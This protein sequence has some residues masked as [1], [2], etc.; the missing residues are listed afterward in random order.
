M[1]YLIRHGQTDW[2][3]A[4]KLQGTT[5]IP[6][7]DTGR[8][9]AQDARPLLAQIHLDVCYSSP[10]QRAAETAGI[11]LEGR[12][13]PI[14]YDD[15]LKEISFGRHEGSFDFFTDP[16]NPVYP[17][18]HD[19]AN[20]DAK[21]DMESL[22]QLNERTASFL[23]EVVAP[24]CKEDKDVLVV[25]HGAMNLSIYNQL[26]DIPLAQF[27]DNLM[28][29]CEVRGIENDVIAGFVR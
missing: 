11:L 25:A 24:L 28:K 14:L 2:N 1:L 6:L 17:L 22:T 13:I 16:E 9:M 29:N 12:D 23:R 3:K 8:Q 21:G 7:N 27:W 5:D 20:Y 4:H 19:P 15:R 10:L 26:Y 18:F